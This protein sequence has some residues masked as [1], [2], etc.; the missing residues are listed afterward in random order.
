[1]ISSELFANAI[2]QWQYS[3]ESPLGLDIV[4]LYLHNISLLACVLRSP[5]IMP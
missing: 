3:Q 2:E 5:L 4:Q 1:M